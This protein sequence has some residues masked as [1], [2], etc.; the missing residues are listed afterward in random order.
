M[1]TT[2]ARSIY[3]KTTKVKRLREDRFCVFFV[4]FLSRFYFVMGLFFKNILSSS[5]KRFIS[6]RIWSLYSN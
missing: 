6:P 1:M 2:I 3:N 5:F 4:L